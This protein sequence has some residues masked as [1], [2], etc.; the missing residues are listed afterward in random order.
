MTKVKVCGIKSPNDIY[1]VN[2]FKPDYIGFVFAES[3]RKV[4][5]D[6]ALALRKIL[7]PEIIPIGVFVNESADNI[8]VLAKNGVIDIIQLHGNETEDF[9]LEVKEKTG[10]Q[11][12]KAVGVEKQEDIE[13]WRKSSSDYL[14]FD[15][16]IPGEG[17][18]FDWNLITKTDKPFFLAGGINP[19]NV[20]AAIKFINPFAVDV[21]SGVE[22]N[23]VKDS[24][25]IDLFI[26]RTKN[27]E[28]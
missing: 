28:H 24:E 12:I 1:A 6:Q 18:R 20:E 3:K 19:D 8:A 7:L 2:L 11:V 21:S 4:T 5:G 17:Q 26:R 16:K 15:Y 9:I 25:K 23:G 14:L 22:T 27:Y 10:K 13:R